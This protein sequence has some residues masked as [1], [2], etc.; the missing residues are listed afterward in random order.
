MRALN[1]VAV[2]VTPVSHMA[3]TSASSSRR[4]HIHILVHFLHYTVTATVLLITRTEVILGGS[5]FHMVYG[6]RPGLCERQTGHL[7]CPLFGCVPTDKARGVD[8]GRTFGPAR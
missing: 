3:D 8:K 4:T 7:Q 1:R 2:E 6:V 5:V